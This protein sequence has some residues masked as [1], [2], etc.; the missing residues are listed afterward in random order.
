MILKFEKKIHVF[1]GELS[2]V[3]Y[4]NLPKFLA[5]QLRPCGILS[6]EL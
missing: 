6:I 3:Y 5:A 4:P 1:V 2:K